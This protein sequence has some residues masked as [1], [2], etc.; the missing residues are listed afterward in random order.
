MALLHLQC[1]AI[2]I[3]K[4]KLSGE[5]KGDCELQLVVNCFLQQSSFLASVFLTLR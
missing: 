3:K 2:P 5:A 1:I 4:E